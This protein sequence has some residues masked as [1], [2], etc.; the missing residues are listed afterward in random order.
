MK[1]PIFIFLFFLL[2]QLVFI[3]DITAQQD[4]LRGFKDEQFTLLIPDGNGGKVHVEGAIESNYSRTVKAEL[5]V[6]KATWTN[7]E[8]LSLS[9]HKYFAL[10]LNRLGGIQLIKEDEILI[11]GQNI[12]SINPFVQEG[13]VQRVKLTVDSG[14][15]L[16]IQDLGVQTYPTMDISELS[17]NKKG[18]FLAVVDYRGREILAAPWNGQGLPPAKPAFSRVLKRGDLGSEILFPISMTALSGRGVDSPLGNPETQEP[19][20]RVWNR[21]STS[22]GYISKVSGNNFLFHSIPVNLI[23]RES[24]VYE[25]GS[26]V[27]KGQDLPYSI[28]PTLGDGIANPFQCRMVF[29][30]TGDIIEELTAFDGQVSTF[31]SPNKAGYF[32]NF[33]GSPIIITGEPGSVKGHVFLSQIRYGK[34]LV[35]PNGYEVSRGFLPGYGLVSKMES[36]IGTE[37]INVPTGVISCE[38]W[39][40]VRSYQN[41]QWHDPVTVFPDGSAALSPNIVMSFSIDRDMNGPTVG[42]KIQFSQA[43]EGSVWLFQYVF[44]LQNQ[45]V[46]ATDVFGQSIRHYGLVLRSELPTLYGFQGLNSKCSA[47]KFGNEW[48]TKKQRNS[49]FRQR[50]QKKFHGL[51]GNWSKRFVAQFKGIKGLSVSLFDPKKSKAWNLLRKRER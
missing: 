46:L 13:V 20:I 26:Y 23:V 11:F 44:V 47:G 35:S 17:W 28:R 30:P 29:G 27:F 34:P 5:A 21:G 32:L 51:R 36:V 9:G 48:F 25:D 1:K 42:N 37:M 19:K 40:G 10:H 39:V 31:T 6:A 45:E 24:H 7:Y 3:A 15:G 50:L 4:D 22:R 16:Q 18:G 43:D 49:E 38:L 14:G 2:V 12:K 41:G 8:Y 33:P